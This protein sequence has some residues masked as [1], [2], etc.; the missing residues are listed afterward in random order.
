MDFDIQEKSREGTPVLELSGSL[1]DT[2]ALRLSR[3]LKTLEA[4]GA[5]R[6]IIDVSKLDFIDSHGLGLLVYHH[7]VMTDSGRQLIIV[8]ANPDP[9]S[10]VRGLAETTGLTKVLTI[11]N[12][13]DFH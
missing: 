10:Y 12:S 13:W 9:Q 7:T 5:P 4:N 11:V 6:I 2:E 3:V 1:M 8:N